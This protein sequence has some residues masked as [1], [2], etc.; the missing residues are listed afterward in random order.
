VLYFVSSMLA[1]LTMSFPL[2]WLHRIAHSYAGDQHQ[3]NL[4]FGTSECNTDMIRT[5][6]LVRRFVMKARPGWVCKVFTVLENELPLQF[7]KPT[8]RWC[9]EFIRDQRP[10]PN[11]PD[12][13]SWASPFIRYMFKV[14]I[15]S[16]WILL[17]LLD[18]RYSFVFFIAG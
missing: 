4:L 7:P 12:N 18:G 14:E 17:L 10:M 1:S 11:P 6:I 5:E 8:E 15:V 2:Q 3:G 9:G 13:Y 16:G